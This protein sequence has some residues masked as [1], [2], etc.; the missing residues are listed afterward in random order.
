MSSVLDGRKTASGEIYDENKL[1]AAHRSYPFNT[2]LRVTN[3]SNG[4]QV[5]VRVNDRGPFVK[6]RVLD[7]SLKA[8]RELNFVRE[9][10]IRVR[11][12]RLEQG[13]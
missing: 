7:V 11:I 9:G 3:L 4:E 12:E 8:A 10:V 1:T 5:V 2:R 13:E 6:N